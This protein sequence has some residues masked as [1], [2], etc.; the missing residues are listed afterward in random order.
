MESGS[1]ISIYRP[2]KM[3]KLT[4]VVVSQI[5][6]SILAGQLHPGD[7]LPPQRDLAEQL[8]TSP[9]VVREALQT[10]EERGLL[11]TRA[12]I[13]TFVATLSSQ[14]I[15]Q[16]LSLIVALRDV[17]FEQLYEVRNLFEAEITALAALRHTPEDMAKLEDA[18]RR[19]EELATV[20]GEFVRADYD[21]HLAL[22][23]ATHNPLFPVLTVALADLL[24]ANRIWIYNHVPSSHARSQEEHRA[25]IEL[26]KL[27]D[28][29]GARK[30]MSQHITTSAIESA[31]WDAN[32]PEPSADERTQ[33]TVISEI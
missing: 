25:I 10:L 7:Q 11:E 1:R 27:R 23:E 9:T 28:S 21:F 4:H 15:S 26:V 13:G 32:V 30:A 33:P 16:S 17:S 5:Q 14:V 18:V 6:E 3:K 24:Q 20:R 29:R 2:V 19:I 8:G 31:H 12:G 22:A